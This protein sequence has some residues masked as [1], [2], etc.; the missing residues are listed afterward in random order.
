M[1]VND[2]AHNHLQS[3]CS[4]VHK[5]GNGQNGRLDNVVDFKCR[6]CLN[7]TVADADDKKVQLRNVE[8]MVVNQ[9]YYLGDMLS[10]HGSVEA[11]SI[12]SIKSGW[13]KFRELLSL[14]KSQVFLHKMK[15]KLYLAC[16]RSVML[17][18]NE[19]WQL[20]ENDIS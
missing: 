5:H 7:P 20:K 13:K 3:L 1:I 11:S 18:G 4:L 12:F 19:T 16:V 9:F 10:S 14:L 8:D 15:G 2:C 17:Y 6:T